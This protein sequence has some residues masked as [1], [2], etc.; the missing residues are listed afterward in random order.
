MIKTLREIGEKYDFQ[1]KEVDD[2]YNLTFDIRNLPSK[3]I[4]LIKTK[5][6]Y[7]ITVIYTFLW[8]TSTSP[9]NWSGNTPDQYRCQI[10][11]K[12]LADSSPLN[13]SILESNFFKKHVKKINFKIR[14]KDKVIHKFLSENAC[15]K[16]IYA[17]CNDSAELSPSI[18]CKTN[19]ENTTLTINFQSFHSNVN[20]LD[21]SINF[22]FQLMKFKKS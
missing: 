8:G 18:E 14:S 21:D 12:F 17:R 5:P 22:C 1:I 13:F 15:L 19:K 9:S 3:T 16:T 2:T 6:N 11:I 20:L 7:S 10:I 4:T